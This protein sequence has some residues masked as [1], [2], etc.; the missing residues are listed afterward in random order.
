MLFSLFLKI[1]LD[2]ASF[3]SFSRLLQSCV[4]EGKKESLNLLILKGLFLKRS[5]LYDLEFSLN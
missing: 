4:V 2:L 3:V 5:L 1:G